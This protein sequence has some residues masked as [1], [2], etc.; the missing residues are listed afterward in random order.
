M[1]D[2]STIRVLIV[3]DEVSIRDSIAAFLD[4]YGFITRSCAST[5]EARDLLRDEPYQVCILD[6][7]LPGLSGEDLILLAHQRYPEMRYIIHTGSISYILPEELLS[8]GIRPQHVFHK[9]IRV[10]S[11]LVKCIKTLVPEKDIADPDA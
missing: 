6:L 11:L 4:D 5:E 9:P 10:L 2:Y 8:I 3:D 7:R 1:A